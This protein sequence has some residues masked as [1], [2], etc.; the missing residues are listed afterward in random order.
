MRA[1]QDDALYLAD[2]D[3]AV[4]RR[5]PLP[6]DVSAPPVAIA[7]PGRPAQVL[8]LDGRVLVTI[9]DPGLLLVMRPDPTAGLV[10]VARVP[11]P[12]DA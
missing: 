8:A 4:L 10:E 11:L 6:V 9:R 7:M 12:A 2:E 3:H 1:P 5:I